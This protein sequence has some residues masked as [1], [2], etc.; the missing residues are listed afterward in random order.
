MQ[1]LPHGI[2]KMLSKSTGSDPRSWRQGLHRPAN[3][4]QC[5]EVCMLCHSMGAMA[6]MAQCHRDASM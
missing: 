3:C 5:S 4:L 2:Q 6:Y 1:A